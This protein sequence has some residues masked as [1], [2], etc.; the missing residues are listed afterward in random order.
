MKWLNEKAGYRS[1][2]FLLSHFNPMS[3]SKSLSLHWRKFPADGRRLARRYADICLLSDAD[4][5]ICALICVHLREPYA[6][7]C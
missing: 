7:K 1:L 2:L 6:S 4:L 5:R 3:F